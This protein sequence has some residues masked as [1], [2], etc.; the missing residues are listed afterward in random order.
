MLS[1]FCTLISSLRII[2]KGEY[3]KIILSKIQINY[4]LKVFIN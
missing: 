4:F 2:Q 3:D 1:K